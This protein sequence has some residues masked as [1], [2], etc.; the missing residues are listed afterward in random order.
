[1]GH[2]TFVRR[3]MPKLQ[4]LAHRARSGKEKSR[5]GRRNP[6][7][8]PYL[9]EFGYAT[10]NRIAARWKGLPQ[11]QSNSSREIFR[12]KPSRAMLRAIF[13]LVVVLA[14]CA[15]QDAASTEY[16]VKAA[17]L[18]NFAKFVEWPAG[19]FRTSD[20]PLVI[21]VLGSNPFGSDLEGS[22]AGKAVGG[23][24]L[25]ISHLPRGL[26][27]RSCQIVF[28]ASSERGQVRE[29]LQQLTGTS[30]LTVSDTSGFTDDGGMINFVWE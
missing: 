21:C 24:R 15:G 29:I 22:I 7:V 6:Y 5:L 18:F 16:Q 11:L 30:A 8:F 19:T 12:R 27:A 3:T 14:R 9:S 23:R 13:V 10:C 26:D 17:Y 25:E 4:L 2:R 28:I 1:M 20:S